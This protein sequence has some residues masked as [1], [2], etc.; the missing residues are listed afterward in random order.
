MPCKH[1]CK[2]GVLSERLTQ[3][4]DLHHPASQVDFAVPLEQWHHVCRIGEHHLGT[5]QRKRDAAKALTKGSAVSRRGSNPN[6]V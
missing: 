2:R 3:L 4:L 5:Q 6:P 1:G